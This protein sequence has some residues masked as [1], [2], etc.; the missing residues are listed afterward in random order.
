[1]ED[2]VIIKFDNVSFAYKADEA[3]TVATG[4]VEASALLCLKDSFSLFWDT[5]D[6]VNRRLRSL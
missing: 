5:T 1:M 3:E 6:A 2:K 4:V